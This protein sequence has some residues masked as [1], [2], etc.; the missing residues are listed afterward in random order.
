MARYLFVGGDGTVWDAK[1]AIP[2]V[3]EI[4]QSELERLYKVGHP[5][6]LL[7]QEAP[8]AKEATEALKTKK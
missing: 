7:V 5:S 6:A 1:G 2:L 8:K 3:P 4:S